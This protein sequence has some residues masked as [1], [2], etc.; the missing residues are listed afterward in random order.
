MNQILISE[1]VYVTP[2]FKKRKKVFRLEFF[3]SVFLLCLLSSYAI[4]AEY[5]RNKSEE[6]SKEILQGIEFKEAS[7]VVLKEQQLLVLELKVLLT[8]TLQFQVF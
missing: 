6:V 4:Y 8:N 7:K 1:K 2:E 3:L 5:D